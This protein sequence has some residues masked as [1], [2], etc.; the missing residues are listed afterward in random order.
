MKTTANTN[1]SPTDLVRYMEE[2]G[3][4]R[5][6]A[7]EAGTKEQISQLRQETAARKEQLLAEGRREF[8]DV[9]RELE[10]AIV[11]QAEHDTQALISQRMVD[12]AE[13]LFD[14]CSTRLRQFADGPDFPGVLR[15]LFA[16]AVG[17][18]TSHF[19]PKRGGK[20]PFVVIRAAP[21]DCNTCKQLV[22]E[23][24]LDARVEADT[25]VWGG[26][27]VH[28]PDRAYTIRNTLA[29]RLKRLEPQL[30][31]VILTRFEASLPDGT[32]Q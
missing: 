1:D 32:S 21:A 8:R 14:E 29:S 30:T 20:S 22:A 11:G 25:A 7:L 17:Y 2:E 3:R 28:V 31:D 9:G 19:A 4:R 23:A 18:A 13:Q 6:E 10:S 26:V 16:E 15:R 27:E 5:C 12:A 24:D